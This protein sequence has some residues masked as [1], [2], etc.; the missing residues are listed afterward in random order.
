MSEPIDYKAAGVDLD[1][2]AETMAL[3]PP[4][5]T[6]TFT[7]A[8]DRVEGRVRR[9]VPAR[10]QHRPAVADLPRPGAGRLD[11]RGGDQ[12]EAGLCHRPAHDGG[13]RP[14]GD[15]G[16][17]LPLRRGRAAA[18]PGLRGDEPRR[19]RADAGRSCRGS[20]TAASM[21]SAPCSAARRRSSPSSTRAGEYDLAGFCVGVVE[22]KHILKGEEIRAGRQGDRAGEL[23]PAFQRLQPGAQ[24]R[25]RPRRPE[26]GRLR[27]RAGPDRRRRVPRRRRGS[28]SG[29]SRRS[30]ATTASSGPCTASRT[31]PAAA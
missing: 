4:L 7:R 16:Q 15:V 17:R 28:T 22:R 29:R 21:P 1:K 20:A 11:R 26:A 3:L 10:R 2:Y 30:T 14:G 9:V 23:G 5:L 6:R 31:S 8:G 25:L 12:A 24:D 27:R 18:L 13:H 19:P